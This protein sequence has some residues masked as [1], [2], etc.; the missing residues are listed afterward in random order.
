VVLCNEE[1]S[2]LPVCTIHRI[3]E[4]NELLSED[5]HGPAPQRFA[6]SA[7]NDDQKS[8]VLWWSLLC[9]AE[10]PQV[11]R[12]RARSPIGGLC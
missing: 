10:Y 6:R 11:C 2:S 1:Q 8:E 5:H 4:R 12:A 9:A 3:L 7:P